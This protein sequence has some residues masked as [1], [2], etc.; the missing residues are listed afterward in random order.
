METTTA[1]QGP[2]PADEQARPFRRLPGGHA[3]GYAD[4]FKQFFRRFYTACRD[5]SK[6]GDVPGFDAGLRQ[7]RLVEAVLRSHR[8]GG[9][10]GV[11]E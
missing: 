4:T 3:E 8:E 7:L 10:V 11:E 6:A 5:R 9:W 2:V 1:S